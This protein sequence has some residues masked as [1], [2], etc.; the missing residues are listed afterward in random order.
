MESNHGASK[1]NRPPAG[2]FFMGTSTS[3]RSPATPE[4]E[5]VREL[6][7]AGVRDV[8]EI[9]RRIVNALGPEVRRDMSGDGVAACLSTLLKG[10]HDAAQ[11]PPADLLRGADSPVRA[12]G[13]LRNRAERIVAAN[14]WASRFSDIALD[15]LGTSVLS[16]LLR[17][18]GDSSRA[19]QTDEHP[20]FPLA[21]FYRE[22]RLDDLAGAFV[23]NDLDRCFQYFVARDISEFV[24]SKA[25]PTVQDAHS[26]VEAVGAH[27]G[28]STAALPWEELRREILAG[29]HLDSALAVDT[30][31]KPVREMIETGLAAISGG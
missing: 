27:C 20:L 16:C 23:G 25:F 29:R 24:G 14:R 10:A 17:P 1:P 30:L 4:W 28:R 21:Q 22:D 15:A 12:A 6:Y 9:S 2:K 8:G 3:E 18:G 11:E 19:G 13:T 7:R 26:L 31:R 5:S